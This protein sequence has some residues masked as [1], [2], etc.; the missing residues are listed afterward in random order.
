M[1]LSIVPFSPTA[2]PLFISE[3][4]TSYKVQIE[5]LFCGIQLIPPFVVLRIVP[6]SPTAVPLYPSLKQ[7]PFKVFVEPLFCGIQ[8]V[9]PFVV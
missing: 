2:I 3:K 7:T 4:E 9:P 1:V 5:P 6:F 8:F